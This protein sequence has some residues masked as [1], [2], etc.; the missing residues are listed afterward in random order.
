MQADALKNSGYRLHLNP[1]SI[2][3]KDQQFPVTLIGGSFSFI[4]PSFECSDHVGLCIRL[5]AV[6]DI[7]HC[8]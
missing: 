5:L 8:P 6:R 3:D 7:S 2:Q 1:L 4:N